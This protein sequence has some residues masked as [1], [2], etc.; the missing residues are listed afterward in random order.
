MTDYL[1]KALWI[2]DCH[3]SKGFEDPRLYTTPEDLT[4]RLKAMEVK[5][6]GMSTL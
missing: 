5:Q 3:K 6:N 2:L 1:A 4:Q